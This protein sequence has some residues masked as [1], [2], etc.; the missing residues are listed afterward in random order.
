MKMNSL[1]ALQTG[2]RWECCA[3]LQAALSALAACMLTWFTSPAAVALHCANQHSLAGGPGCLQAVLRNYPSRASH[4]CLC[5]VCERVGTPG[6]ALLEAFK[7]R[8]YTELVGGKTM[9]QVRI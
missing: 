8:P 3:L 7:P 4:H 2:E 5:A 6:E 9:A 1:A